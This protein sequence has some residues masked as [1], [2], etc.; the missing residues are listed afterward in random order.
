MANKK[1]KVKKQPNLRRISL[2]LAIIGGLCFVLYFVWVF[3]FEA[4]F[5]FRE[6]ETEFEEA[7]RFRFEQKPQWL[8]KEVGD[9][10]KVTLQ[11]MYDEQ[12][13]E[14]MLVPKQ[15]KVCD[16][17]SWVRVIKTGEDEY[18]YYTYLKCGKYESDIDHTGPE[19]TLN[20]D[21]PMY[22]ILGSTYEEPGVSKVYD[23]TDGEIDVNQVVIDT[24]NLNTSLEGTY[25]V[26]Y[27]VS[28]SLKNQTV[29]RRDVH[30]V[31]SLNEEILKNTNNTG[32]YRGDVSNNYVLFSG[33]LFQ[34]LK[35]NGDGSVKIVAT[36]NVSNVAYGTTP[37]F[38]GSNIQKW[39]NEVFYPSIHKPEYLVPDVEW[40]I[41]VIT[42]A[43][44]D[45]NVCN[46]KSS[47][48]AVGLLSIQDVKDTYVGDDSYL[49]TQ[50]VYWLSNKS[51]DTAAWAKIFANI[52]VSDY[53][54]DG[55]LLGVRPVLHLK[56]EM[57]VV[58]GN[59]TLNNPYKLDDYEYG[60]D[61]DLLNSRLIGEYVDFS[62]YTFR[63]SGFDEENNTRLTM[64]GP[65]MNQTD[66]TNI[67]STYE[68]ESPIK[69]FNPVEVGNIGYYLNNEAIHLFQDS[70]IVSHKWDVPLL[71]ETQMYS[72][73]AKEEVEAK[74]SIPASYEMFSSTETQ[75]EKGTGMVWLRDYS[76]WDN[77]G[78]MVN[79]SNG[80]LFRINYNE[81]GPLSLKISLYI[82]KDAK[83]S[84][85]KGT[86]NNPYYVK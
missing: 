43:N 52:K 38:E 72:D 9:S 61:N 55:N 70:Y 77:Q 49:T 80:V 51:R 67:L 66:R 28:D 48:S 5:L 1:Q 24:S 42:D 22:I 85:G 82:R 16:N 86:Y 75:F 46:T 62:G 63:I 13:L 50:L 41:D 40:C 31:R 68:I 27:T 56:P 57:K 20:G 21:N 33:M 64:V 74:I 25:P 17:T 44:G 7:V 60:Q 84:N 83:I 23:D 11:D 15:K 37:T 2:I 39:L 59:G 32:I 79:H 71:E 14:T 69:K 76:S 19:I 3:G 18:R 73:F 54:D 34:I 26:Y 78:I 6:Q 35:I 8:P 45:T 58:G 47:P 53:S 36:D 81:Y 4:R 30:V 10:R 12:R 29:L 65:L